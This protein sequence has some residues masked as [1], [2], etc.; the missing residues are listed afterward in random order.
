MQDRSKRSLEPGSTEGHGLYTGCATEPPLMHAQDLHLGID[1]SRRAAASPPANGVGEQPRSG[2]RT[3][4]WADP[5]ETCVVL[6]VPM[7]VRRMQGPR[8]AVFP[9]I[10]CCANVQQ[11]LH[12]DRYNLPLLQLPALLWPILTCGD[13]SRGDVAH[14]PKLPILTWPREYCPH[15]LTLSRSLLRKPNKTRCCG[16]PCV[17]AAAGAPSATAS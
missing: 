10:T 6:P 3:K 5:G 2:M 1:V 9:K 13:T 15:A 8:P 4:P 16:T 12:Q 7:T 11:S 14:Y 17:G